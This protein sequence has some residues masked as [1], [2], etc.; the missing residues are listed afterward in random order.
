MI[1]LHIISDVHPS[2]LK[3]VLDCVSFA[4]VQHEHFSYKVRALWK[5]E[6]EDVIL[7]GNILESRSPTETQ[8]GILTRPERTDL[9]SL[10]TESLGKGNPP[11]T[12]M[13]SN[14]PMDQISAFM[15]SYE[16]PAT[17]AWN[18]RKNGKVL[19]NLITILVRRRVV[20]RTMCSKVDRR[21]ENL[22]TQNLKK[23]KN[24]AFLFVGFK[25]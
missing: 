12:R 13:Y 9:L 24:S 7:C 1:F 16:L 5:K 19:T 8:Y 2:V 25:L 10:F 6:D 17:L 3:N 14:T 4:R 21:F 20:I 22:K 18:K 23:Y 15:P 11:A